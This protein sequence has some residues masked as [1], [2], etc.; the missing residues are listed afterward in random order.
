M[1]SRKGSS[2]SGKS[3]KQLQTP[4]VAGGDA[5]DPAHSPSSYSAV[6][7]GLSITTPY[8]RPKKSKMRPKSQRTAEILMKAAKANEES[9]LS[10]TKSLPQYDESAPKPSKR[11]GKIGESAPNEAKSTGRASFREDA[12]TPVDAHKTKLS[13]SCGLA[14]EEPRH[15]SALPSTERTID[16]GQ[17]VPR[18]VAS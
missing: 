3:G 14:K 9:P 7:P 17:D 16:D 1:L 5:T 12:K 10:Q 13:D 18:T 15:R 2:T 4:V 6:A 8:Q 11:A